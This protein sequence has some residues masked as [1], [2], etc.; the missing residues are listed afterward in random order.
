MSGGNGVK[1]SDVG[2][3]QGS[4]SRRPV[5]MQNRGN[6]EKKKSEKTTGLRPRQ[7]SLRRV[8]DSTDLLR[9]KSAQDQQSKQENSSDPNTPGRD[10][11][12]RKFTVANVGDNGKIYLRLVSCCAQLDQGSPLNIAACANFLVADRLKK[13]ILEIFRKF[14]LSLRPRKRILFP[15][16]LSLAHLTT[17]YILVI[18]FGHCTRSLYASRINYKRLRVNT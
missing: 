6:L 16:C 13:H 7:G 10:L 2:M 17:Y 18:V 1:A 14:L 3:S 9:E 8:K 4:L 11:K 15:P 5:A 12:A